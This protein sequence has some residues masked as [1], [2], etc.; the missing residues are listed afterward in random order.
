MNLYKL[1]ALL[2][3]HKKIIKCVFYER[4]LSIIT[5]ITI[6]FDDIVQISFTNENINKC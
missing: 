5:I 3:F 6:K 4:I 2:E 1:C